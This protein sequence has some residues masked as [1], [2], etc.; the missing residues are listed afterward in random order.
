MSGLGLA[1]LAT[2]AMAGAPQPIPGTNWTL[3]E[4]VWPSDVVDVLESLSQTL[5]EAYRY[6]KRPVSIQLTPAPRLPDDLSTPHTVAVPGRRHISL[7]AQGLQETIEQWQV[8]Q[9]HTGDT[10]VLARQLLSRQLVHALTHQVDREQG[11]STDA[12]WRQLSGWGRWPLH[13]TA[14][15]TE[16]WGFAN[17]H[18]QASAREDFATLAEHYFVAEPL[19]GERLRSARCRAPSK[20]T[21]LATRAAE[22]S[23]GADC[24]ALTDAELDAH[25]IEHIE[26]LYAR[27][28]AADPASVVGHTMVALVYAPDEHGLQR[29]DVYGLVA[30]VGDTRPGNPAYVLRGLSGGFPSQVQWEPLEATMLRYTEVEDRDLLR[31]R[32][33]LDAAQQA[34]LLERLNELRG[35]WQRPYAFLH[36]NCTELPRQ[37]AEA[38]LGETLQLPPVFGPDVLLGVLLRQGLIVP[39]PAQQPEEFSISSRAAAS[40]EMRDT[41][42]EAMRTAHP[43]QPGLAEALQQTHSHRRDTRRQGYEALGEL[44]SH[45]GEDLESRLAL[46][47]FFAL[48]DAME[49]PHHQGEELGWETDATIDSIWSAKADNRALIGDNDAQ[50]RSAIAR[51]EGVMESLTSTP[52][53]GTTHTP[54]HRVEVG[55]LVQVVDGRATPWM[56]VG[57]QLYR[58]RLGEARQYRPADGLELTLLAGQTWLQM[59]ERA[60]M[61][62]GT[63]AAI[64][65]IRK[66]RT[67]GNPAWYAVVGELAHRWGAT[68]QANW[69]EGGGVLEVWQRDARRQHVHFFGGVSSQSF[70]PELEVTT[71]PVNLA[72]PLG[73]TA[74]FGAQKHALT[75]LSLEAEWRPIHTGQ[76]IQQSWQANSQ[77]QLRLGELNG[78]DVALVAMH[79]VEQLG[80]A[81][82]TTPLRHAVQLALWF[83]P[84]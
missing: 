41:L 28:S 27:S 55:S 3:V 35:T 71:P 81:G 82:A 17:A 38:A 74:R 60:V 61:S 19:P 9:H 66:N 45:W 22:T 30:M 68:L 31:F 49:Q 47:Q 56:G 84:Y 2:Q 57:S 75:A 42:A 11:W 20:W 24:G 78:I 54:L 53:R 33:E 43:A 46:D 59:D 72:T 77:T 10:A 52:R 18:G 62:A 37:L 29:R 21:F 25:A 13:R 7:G 16:P 80:N 70:W 39:L 8:R 69:A 4:A 73:L 1:L 76:G 23:D 14:L 15:E 79:R 26:L 65:H 50:L 32:W 12:A 58:T 51:R 63:I 36:R 44:S 83:E 48:S 64:K 34:A 40:R 5:P 6:P 67:V